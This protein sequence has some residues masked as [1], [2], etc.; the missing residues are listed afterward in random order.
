MAESAD[1][2]TCQEVVELSSDY[3]EGELPAAEAELF[4][5]HLNFCEGCVWYV[6]EMRR[7]IATG[8][9]LRED[10]VPDE[11]LDPLLE[12]FRGWKRS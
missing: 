2:I 10:Q 12:A 6:D 8:E 11:V 9:R 1:H 4:E 7:T 3:L 5:Q